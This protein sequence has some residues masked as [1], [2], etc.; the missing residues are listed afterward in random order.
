MYRA[1]PLKDSNGCCCGVRSWISS[2]II[3][4]FLSTVVWAQHGPGTEDLRGPEGAYVAY[5]AVILPGPTADS[6]A[7]DIHY[8]IQ[9]SFFV[10]MRT[11]TGKEEAQGE[12]LVEL[13]NTSGEAT[14]REVRSIRL[15]R[16]NQ[17][18]S[19]ALIPDHQDH[20]RFV[21]PPGTYTI[22][23]DVRAQESGRRFLERRRTLEILAMPEGSL[24]PRPVFGFLETAVGAFVPFNRGG[25]CRF[26]A[27]GGMLVHF[28]PYSNGPQVLSWK[29]SGMS[30][31]DGS[32]RADFSGIDT[33]SVGQM[34]I[35]DVSNDRPEY[36]Q[37]PAENWGS[38][39]V[40][41][42]LE[43]LEPGPYTIETAL[44]EG[45]SKVS[46][47]YRL[48]VFWPDRPL[49]LT[50]F[51]LA[52]DALRHI[53]DPEEVEDMVG[54]FAD[55][56]GERFR[57]FWRRLDPDTATMYNPA[58]AE[59]Y[60]RVDEAIRKFSTRGGNDGY[61]TDRGRILILY[62]SPTTSQRIFKP[63]IGPREIWVYE[64]LKKRFIFTDPDRTG[65]YTLTQTE[66]L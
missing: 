60:R 2:L 3:S 53:A 51:D 22:V 11:S 41:L 30:D 24:L 5:D 20:V 37:V 12:V 21:L 26:G 23:L 57:E 48:M 44:S 1:K 54:F 46:Q 36:R 14:A 6:F 35:P 65:N 58:Q 33:V 19:G 47:T 52:V 59:Y 7:V 17:P 66:D 63:N 55:G 43:R 28:R 27:V 39:Y 64:H 16:P 42:P 9:Q 45:A 56:G 34:Y 4:A 38:A 18:A 62:G 29:L 15:D 61:K 10:F 31:E 49:S 50:T 8:R 25:G 13:N 32:A 40:R